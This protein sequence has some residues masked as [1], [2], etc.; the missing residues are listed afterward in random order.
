MNGKRTAKAFGAVVAAFVAATGVMHLTQGDREAQ[1]G[2]A[3]APNAAVVAVSSQMP[4]TTKAD[5]VAASDTNVDAAENAG[6]ADAGATQQQT[7]SEAAPKPTGVETPGKAADAPAPQPARFVALNLRTDAPQ[8]L[9]GTAARGS[10]VIATANGQEIARATASDTGLWRMPLEKPLE[11]ENYILGLS[12]LAKDGA[13][14]PGQVALI[15]RAEDGTR[16]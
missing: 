2:E 5:D 10:T 6:A 15:K 9:S 7:D 11:G 1:T 13:R 3:P 4:A 14:V 16:A 8:I 12:S